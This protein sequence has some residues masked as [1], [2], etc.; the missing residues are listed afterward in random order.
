MPAPLSQSH[1]SRAQSLSYPKST[2]A[3]LARSGSIVWFIIWVPVLSALFSF[4]ILP[5]SQPSRGHTVQQHNLQN[6]K[7]GS[8]VQIT[9]LPL[10]HCITLGKFLTLWPHFLGCKFGVLQMST[11]GNT[12]T[13]LI[14]LHK[15][16]G[17]F[18]KHSNF[19]LFLLKALGACIILLL[20]WNC[21]IFPVAEGLR[22]VKERMK[23]GFIWP[24]SLIMQSIRAQKVWS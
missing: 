15:A 7:V 5:T 4:T 22:K 8:W 18:L 14:G 24:H 12:R 13:E 23:G 1:L 20:V 3:K 16:P 17:E 9:A 2:L 6:L 19:L 10:T 21:Y 11:Q